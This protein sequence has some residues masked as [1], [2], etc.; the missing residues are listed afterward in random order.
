MGLS[1]AQA[2]EVAY[3][4]GQT[5]LAFRSVIGTNLGIGSPDIFM[6]GTASQK[7]PFLPQIASGDLIVS[8]ALTEPN[9]GSDMAS[10]RTKVV[11]DG[12]NYVL[13]G[14]KCY[15]TN[16]QHAGAFS[17]MV[18]RDGNGAG[19]ISAFILPVD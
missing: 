2:C 16:V 15:I 5:A 4:L 19:A 17:L 10:L 14:S 7:A 9:A 11:C 12:D 1:M 13:H 3:K 6:D 8:F 18:C